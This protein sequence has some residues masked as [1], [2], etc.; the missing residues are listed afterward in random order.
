MKHYINETTKEVFA[1][2]ADGTQHDFIKDGL[3]PITDDELSTLRSEQEQDRLDS[4]TYV[5]I[6]EAEYPSIKDVVVAMAEKIEGNDA[7]WLDITAQ[8]KA[9]KLRIPKPV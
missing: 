5:E 4:L 2:K 6:R 8:R 7:M 1:Y 3:V 9:V